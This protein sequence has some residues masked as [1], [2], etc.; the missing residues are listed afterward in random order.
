MTA[1][2][3]IPPSST[4]LDLDVELGD[5]VRPPWRKLRDEVRALGDDPP[6]EALHAVRIRAKRCRYAAEAV[7]PAVGKPAKAFAKAVAGLQEVLG[8][9]QDAVVAGQWLRAH[10]T[11]GGG[12]SKRRTW[13]ASSPAIETVAAEASRAEWP[14][15]WEIASNKRLRDWL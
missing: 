9:H 1:S 2:H 3:V 10:A 14:E 12:A 5:L 4:S 13:P 15:A 7:A 6:D 11:E 8:E